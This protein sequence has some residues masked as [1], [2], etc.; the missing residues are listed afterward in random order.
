MN[1]FFNI[2]KS[3]KLPIKRVCFD[4]WD[5]LTNFLTRYLAIINCRR[6]KLLLL[7]FVWLVVFFSSRSAPVSGLCWLFSVLHANLSVWVWI[8]YFVFSYN[9][10][11]EEIVS[12]K[13]PDCSTVACTG[14]IFLGELNY[15]C[16]HYEKKFI[17]NI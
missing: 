1:Y 15:D 8:S 12:L 13:C 16:S 11:W 3:K 10:C 5:F 2:I 17:K 9:Y 4:Y 6:R 14:G 7:C